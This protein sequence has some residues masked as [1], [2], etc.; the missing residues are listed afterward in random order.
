MQKPIIPV[1]EPGFDLR[2]IVANMKANLGI[3]EITL[4]TLPRI[5]RTGPSLRL[6]IHQITT[7]PKPQY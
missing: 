5:L 2:V 6:L 7:F 1:H 4:A 3:Q